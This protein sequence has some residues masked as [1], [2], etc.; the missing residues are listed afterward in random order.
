MKITVIGSY[1]E[2]NRQSLLG[3]KD[4]FIQ[5]CETIGKNLAEWGHMLV[6]PRPKVDETAE[7]YALKGFKENSNAKYR[8]YECMEH[9]GDPVLKAHFD[10]VERS[11]AAIFIGGHGSTYAAGLV[12]LRRRKLVIPIPAFGGSAKE[13][14]SISEIDNI[15]VDEIRN[16]EAG[17][18]D[19]LDVLTLAI[20][21]SLK[22]FPHV[23]II[24]GRGDSG[25][26]LQKRIIQNSEYDKSPIYGI[27]QPLIMDLTGM[28]AVAV[29]DVFES[30][31]SQVSAAIAIV[32]ADDVG[33]FAR[34]QGKELSAKELRLK[35]RARENVW[36]EIGWFWGRL[37]RQRVFLW[38]KDELDLPSDLQGAAWTRADTLDGAWKSIEAFISKLRIGK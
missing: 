28:G 19:W 22:T 30:S 26:E 8:Y 7:G 6:V 37:D 12:A 11:D 36:V 13:L 25:D 20:Q 18:K 9:T 15:L 14:C 21:S 17:G 23:L 33:G 3:N 32:T 34:S 5:A 4:E 10:A 16:L 2:E 31:A 38:L 29:P 27:A 1:R 24:H 35:P